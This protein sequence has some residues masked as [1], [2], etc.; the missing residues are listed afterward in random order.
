[1]ET[2][3]INEE[4]IQPNI[5]ANTDNASN[6]KETITES[7]QDEATSTTKEKK[8]NID[9]QRRFTISL[10]KDKDQQAKLITTKL[11]EIGNSPIGNIDFEDVVLYLFEHKLEKSD[12]DAIRANAFNRKMDMARIK[13]NKENKTQY[14]LQEFLATA[15]SKYLQ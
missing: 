5:L 8:A 14:S 1:M 2:D 9:I 11:L 10:K 13:F 3:S 15:V 7:F 4:T 6:E 12:H